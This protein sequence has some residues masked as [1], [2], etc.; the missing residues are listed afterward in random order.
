MKKFEIGAIEVSPAASDAL[1][2]NALDLATYLARHQNGDWGDLEDAHHLRNDWALEHNGVIRS[3]YKLPDGA[4]ILVNTTADRPRTWVMLE[5]EY[6][7][8]E[9][10][11]QEGYAL[12]ARSYD[13]EKNPL[14]AVEEP[15]ID[16]ILARLAVTQALDAGTGTG[17]YA[18][19]LARRG[20]KVCAFDQ[21]PEMLEVARQYARDEELKI[22][23]QRGS[24]DA[25]PFRSNY[26]ELVVC[27]LV[28][29]HI[30]NLLQTID[31]FSRVTKDGGYL[32]ITDLHP[33]A[34]AAD[35]RTV[36]AQAEAWY[37]LPN[38]RHT[39]DDYLEAVEAAGFRLLN[40]I[41]LQLGDMPDETVPFYKKWVREQGD[42]LFSLIIFAQKAVSVD[43]G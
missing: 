17:R 2:A 40:M 27:G 42:Q 1:T 8:K 18:R 24:I 6:Q 31:E 39:R 23:F 3:A 11:T 38:I 12:W 20:V 28:L 43:K 26:F 30:P 19:K 7:A 32:L 33:E 21:S 5:T 10:G 35:W 4:T 36:F 16:L 22:N 13:Q 25:I 9:V 29:C 41:D 37:Q 34:L 14:I 15:H